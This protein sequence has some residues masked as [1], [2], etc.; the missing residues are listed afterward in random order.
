MKAAIYCRVST[1]DQAIDGTSLDSQKEACLVK[2]K[3]L[4]YETSEDYT[5]LETYSGLSLDRPK[6]NE[7]REWVRDKQVDAVI[8]YTLDRLSR[9]PVHFIILQEELERV[10]VALIMVTED[11][12]SSDM[13]KLITYIKGFAAKLEAEK[14][15]ERTIRGKMQRVKEGRLPGGRFTKLYGYNYIKGKGL[16]EGIRYKNNDES[17]VVQEICRLFIEESMSLGKIMQRLNTFGILPP[18]GKGLWNRTGVH[19]ILRNPAYI[20][21]TY[22]FTRYKV[23]AKRHLKQSRRNKFTHVVMRPRDKWVEL[24]GATPAIISEEIFNQVQWKLKRNKEL[25]SRNTKHDYL[26]AGYVFCG[27]CGRRYTAHTKG[28]NAYYGCPKCRKRNLNTKYLE[29]SI[30]KQIEDVLSKPEVVMAGIEAIENDEN[31]EERSHKDLQSIELKIRHMEKEKDR[32]WKAFQ[33][34]GDEA[35]FTH[36]IKEIML[37]IEELEKQKVELE[38]KIE[39]VG[40]AEANIQSIKEYCELVNQN[41]G[42]L[43]FSE[44]RK[45]LESLKIKVIAGEDGLKL[46]GIIPI[47][48]GQCA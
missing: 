46:E 47:V 40:Q 10:D 34:T 6:L 16:G 22:L 45:A 12:D 7:L 30:W 38:N 25:A 28:R 19:Y 9:D 31:N 14:I 11:V 1:E 8:A 35:K 5:I 3:E 21:R 26:L 24:E 36:E 20:G 2:A 17:K 48:S 13:G 41:L 39:L 33:I 27:H 44:K 15:K 23:E 32:A 43:S 29:S 37:R 18:S 4:G 42:N